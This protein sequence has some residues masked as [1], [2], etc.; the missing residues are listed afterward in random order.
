MVDHDVFITSSWTGWPPCVALRWASAHR[1]SPHSAPG[2]CS[3]Q[4]LLQSTQFLLQ[5][6]G[7]N[8]GS[9]AQYT[10]G[11]RRCMAVYHTYIDRHDGNKGE[12]RL[13]RTTMHLLWDRDGFRNNRATSIANDNARLQPR[14]SRL[15]PHVTSAARKYC[16]MLHQMFNLPRQAV[17]TMDKHPVFRSN[18]SS[19]QSEEHVHI[20]ISS[21]NPPTLRFSFCVTLPAILT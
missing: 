18:T 1:L 11:W 10:T 14:L 5:L 9:C 12:Q 15:P 16:E 19:N 20:I 21:A 4:H 17:N 6:H 13:H 8:G 3:M 2:I 7:T